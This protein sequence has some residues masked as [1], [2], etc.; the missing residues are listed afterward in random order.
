MRK[1][2]MIALDEAGPFE[3]ELSG[4]LT[5]ESFLKLRAEINAHTFV[6]FQTRK[7]ELMDERVAAFKK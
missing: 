5:L 4:D 2:L 3:T 7:E 6:L 1:N